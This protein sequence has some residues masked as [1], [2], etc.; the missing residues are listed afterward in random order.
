MFSVVATYVFFRYLLLPLIG[1][2]LVVAIACVCYTYIDM[3]H[4]RP[5]KSANVA[6]TQQSTPRDTAFMNQVVSKPNRFEQLLENERKAK[7][8]KQVVVF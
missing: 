1:I 5:T 6:R 7:A 2:S 8:Q 4:T 3:K